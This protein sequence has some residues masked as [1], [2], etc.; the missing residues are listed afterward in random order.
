MST[1]RRIAPTEFSGS[2]TFKGDRRITKFDLGGQ[3]MFHGLSTGAIAA[4]AG[5]STAYWTFRCGNQLAAVAIG[6]QTLLGPAV[7]TT[8]INVAGDQVDNDGWELRGCSSL[9]LG[10]LDKDYFT[11][12][13]SKAFYAKC[14][15]SIADV[16]GIDDIRFEYLCRA[17][18]N[19]E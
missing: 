17:D 15:F 3:V 2:V 19:C 9:Q 13:T 5:G 12:G 16:S 10:T 11:V 1:F 8:G 6:T 4:G 7:A 14:K 18:E